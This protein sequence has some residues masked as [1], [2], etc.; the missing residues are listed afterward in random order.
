MQTARSLKS[1]PQS[2]S[3]YAE[4]EAYI[5]V[6]GEVVAELAERIEL[7]ETRERLGR[8]ALSPAGSRHRKTP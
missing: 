4:R 8:I 6:L 2:T 3:A 7:L 1:V 5:S